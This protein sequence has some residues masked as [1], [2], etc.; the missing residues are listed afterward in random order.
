MQVLWAGEEIMDLLQ[1]YPNVRAWIAGHK[2]IPSKVERKGILHLLSP[3]LIQAPCGF[4]TIDIHED[5]I[6]SEIHP[7][8]EQDLA[9]L[10]R[11]A[12]GS[13][14]VHRHGNDED[15]DFWWPW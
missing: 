6:L 15:R 7:I 12:Y 14:Y 9:D 13:E 1:T 4:R 11:R 2:N 3:Q 5:G 8:A 10:S